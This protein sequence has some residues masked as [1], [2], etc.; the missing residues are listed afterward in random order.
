[1]EEELNQLAQEKQKN[2]SAAKNAFESRVKET[3]QKAIDENKINA[4]K[5]GSILTQDIDT[6]G[7]LIG[8]SATSQEKALTTDGSDTISVADIRAE[9]FDGENIVVG[10]TDY[11]RSELISGPFSLREKE[12]DLEN[13]E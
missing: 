12:G 13:A 5:H 7:N 11:G 2:E 10:K 9:L 8:V 1:M 6:E 3:K 4:L